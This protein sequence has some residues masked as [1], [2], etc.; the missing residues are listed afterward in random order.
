MDNPSRP[1][2]RS[3]LAGLSLVAATLTGGC[4]LPSDEPTG[5]EFSWRFLEVNDLDGEENQRFRSCTGV[6]MDEVVIS[7]TD[8]TDLGR[9]EIF[10][11]DCPF[12]FQTISEVQTETPDAFV[13]LK[14]REY[15]LTVDLV[16][17][18]DNGDEPVV[19]RAREL[20]VDVLDRTITVQEFDF[21][22]EP[23][24]WTLELAGADSCDAVSLTLLYANPERDL[25]EPPRESD[26][27]IGDVVYRESLQTLDGL[28]LGGEDASCASLATE[29]RVTALDPGAYLLEV[30]VD[31]T[32]CRIETTVG[33][34]GGSSQIDLADLPCD[35]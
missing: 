23:V 28:S 13:E 33:K 15:D 27:T 11:Y 1:T 4:V 17:T 29:Q 9:N 22:L 21:G 19:R 35:G 8:P 20:T 3:L 32:T 12:G 31:G 5:L 7:I 24:E 26:G 25:S 18:V 6:F 14:P 16:G 34:Q 2:F 30:D 10:R